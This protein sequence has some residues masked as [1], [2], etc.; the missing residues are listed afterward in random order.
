MRRSDIEEAI[1][2][3][4]RAACDHDGKS[5]E[6]HAVTLWPDGQIEIHCGPGNVSVGENEYSGRTHAEHT[7]FC[8]RAI[9]DLD[10][11]GVYEWSYPDD[12]VEAKEA[13]IDDFISEQFAHVEWDDIKNVLEGMGVSLE[14]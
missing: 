5:A 1:E 8:V 12:P 6:W 3:A 11:H 9:E 14:D 10:P 13:A 4:V 7:I 2:D